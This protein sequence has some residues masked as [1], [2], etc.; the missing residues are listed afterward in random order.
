VQQQDSDLIRRFLE[1]DAQA[2]KTIDGWI[3]R[4]MWPY[5]RRLAEE[6][7]D[8][9]QDVRLELTRLLRNGEFRG[10]ASLKTYVWRVANHSSLDRVRSQTRWRWID[11]EGIRESLERDGVLSLREGIGREVRDLAVRV[12]RE[13][14]QECRRLWGMLVEGL[15]YS[16]MSERWGVAEGALRVKVLRCRK[17]AMAIRERL[18]GVPPPS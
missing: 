5:R 6:L 8:V 17:K 1:G 4:A 3:G 15:S 12:I 13:I 16:E 18:A 10:E 2:L 11:L 7:E 14:P 9:C